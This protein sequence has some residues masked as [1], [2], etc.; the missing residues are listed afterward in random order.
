MLE[1]IT[2]AAVSLGAGYIIDDYLSRRNWI[3]IF[4]ST[5]LKIEDKYPELKKTEKNKI[6]KRYL[7]KVPYG[8][9]LSDFERRKEELE[10]ALHEP[11]KCDLTH[12]YSIAI[13]IYHL[14]YKKI[15]KLI[16]NLLKTNDLVF[17][18]G[19]TLTTEGEEVV[20]LEF[21]RSNSHMLVCGGTG[22]GKTAF[23]Q[24]L[25]AQ[26]M[27]KRNL[28]VYICDLKATGSYN[29][30]KNCFNLKELVKNDI[31][32]VRI[33][34]KILNI[35]KQRYKKL[36]EH[37]LNDAGEYNEKFTK[38]KMNRIILVVEEF[39]ILS[40]NKK[41][42]DLLNILLAQ[43][44][45]AGIHI[46]LTVQRPD[47][48]TLDTRLKNNLSYTV[49]F[50]AKN[51]S[52]SETYL[53]K[54]DY[55]AATDLRKPGEAILVKDDEDIYFKSY[56]STNE[57]ILEMVRKTYVI[58]KPP[59]SNVIELPPAEPPKVFMKQEQKSDEELDD[60]VL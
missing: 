7:F 30:F 51:S 18:V 50:K 19:I 58:K 36:D 13:Q 22:K 47:A 24:N 57:E 28:E 20:A 14:A 35:M 44:S 45:G 53:D 9:C 56:Y 31:D 34:N 29:A 52:S 4:K 1:L 43:A 16:N 5:G 21:S 10:M 54:G 32:T 2:M 59:E 8:L 38:E 41:V 15:Y 37:N 60:D 46:F 23:M 40:K 39:V 42:I 25:I 3:A 6:G 26:A 49:A 55:R 48:K 33:L 27:L 12:D 17:N 11:L